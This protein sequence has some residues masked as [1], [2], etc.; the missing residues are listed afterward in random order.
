MHILGHRSVT[1]TLQL[2][3]L[4][5]AHQVLAQV[6]GKHRVVVGHVDRFDLLIGF[7]QLLHVVQSILVVHQLLLQR[8][9]VRLARLVPCGLWLLMNVGVLGLLAPWRDGRNE[10]V[11]PTFA[12]AVLGLI[13]P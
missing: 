10:M 12:L 7:A 5:R 4:P 1:T 3:D 8:A 9:E 13:G 2:L 6:L 11:V